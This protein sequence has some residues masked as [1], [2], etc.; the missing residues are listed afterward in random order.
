M[1]LLMTLNDGGPIFFVSL[2][3]KTKITWSTLL[4]WKEGAKKRGQLIFFRLSRNMGIFV[5]YN[6]GM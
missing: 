2:R 3:R 4:T 5:A 6:F 1:G